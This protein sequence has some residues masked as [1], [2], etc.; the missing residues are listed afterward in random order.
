MDIFAQLAQSIIKEQESI[1]GPVALEQ[2]QKVS[3]LKI[4][5]QTSAVVVEGNKSAVIEQLIEKY[6]DLFGLA[7]VEVCRD[8]VKGL[9]PKIPKEQLPPLLQ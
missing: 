3:G 6:R 9:L 4:D 5:Q 8:A 1:I 2:A 7:S